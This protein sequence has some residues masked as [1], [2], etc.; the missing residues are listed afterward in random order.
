MELPVYIDGKREGTLTMERHGAAT[1]I[2]ADIRDVGRVVRL[3]LYGDGEGYLG[4]PVPEN[5]RQVLT[6]R[7]TAL[8]MRRLPSAP[9]YAAEAPMRGEARRTAPEPSR[10][11]EHGETAPERKTHVVWRG[12]KPYY[13]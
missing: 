1:V 3:R 4:I 13:F 9:T 8:E 7:L 2:R 12:G 5:G 11:P 6:K 10:M